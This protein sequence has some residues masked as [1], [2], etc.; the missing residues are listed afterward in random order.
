MQ[1]TSGAFVTVRVR[2]SILVEIKF[3]F[4]DGLGRDGEH[5]TG[6]PCAI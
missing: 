3:R 2:A 5:F 1:I 4:N 6:K